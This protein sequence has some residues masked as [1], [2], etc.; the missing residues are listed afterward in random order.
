MLVIS[1]RVVSWA[2]KKGEDNTHKK[3]EGHRSID[4]SD[5]PLSNSPHKFDSRTP[6]LGNLGPTKAKFTP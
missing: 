5:T 2:R 3:E 6:D 4:I 1:R